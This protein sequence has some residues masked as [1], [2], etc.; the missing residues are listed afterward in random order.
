MKIP[1]FKPSRRFLGEYNMPCLVAEAGNSQLSRGIATQY[2]KSKEPK[3]LI[4]LRSKSP[5]T[6]TPWQK[7]VLKQLFE[8]DGLSA[9]VAEGIK[10]LGDAVY[11]AGLSEK[12]TLFV[13]KH[14]FLPYVRVT[15]VVID[16]IKR[17][18]LIKL[19]DRVNVFAEHGAVIYQKGQGWGFAELDH[20][21]RYEGAFEKFSF[22]AIEAER[23]RQLWQK[24]FDAI[25]PPPND[26][27][28]VEK[29]CSLIVGRWEPDN[30]ETEKLSKKLGAHFFPRSQNYV[31]SESYV[32]S[33]PLDSGR[34]LEMRRQGNWITVKRRTE[35]PGAAGVFQNLQA[36]FWCDG[37]QLVTAS[38]EVYRQTAERPQA[39]YT[40]RAELQL[41]GI[42][43]ATALALDEFHPR[44][45]V[46]RESA[47]DVVDRIFIAAMQKDFRFL[48]VRPAL[49]KTPNVRRLAM[50]PLE[51]FRVCWFADGAS[52]FG[53]M[54]NYSGEF[55]TDYI[56]KSGK[57]PVTAQ[58][59]PAT[60]ELYVFNAD[61]PSVTVY[62]VG[63]KGHLVDEGKQ[64]QTIPLPG[65]PIAATCDAQT[66]LVYCSLASRNEIA[67]I[68]AKA[69]KVI[70]VWPVAPGNTPRGLAIDG[71]FQRLFVNCSNQKLLMLDSQ[72]GKIIESVATGEGA[73]SCV[74]DSQS[75]REIIAWHFSPE[76]GCPFWLD[77]AKKNFDPRGGE[78]LRRPHREVPALPG[79]VAARPAAR[80]LGAGAIQGQ[81][82]QHL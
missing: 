5:E 39:G 60:M 67:V 3:F 31:F 40:L 53:I 49:V 59:Q 11:D 55:R 4:Y 19:D 29:D 33:S 2:P 42:E 36:K 81:A 24:K 72:C 16:D 57:S 66:G 45:I 69:H 1:A 28:P 26:K 17:K 63:N 43:R 48:R 47:L 77:W 27:V 6:I 21:I 64:M 73:G 7:K 70:A 35:I 44:L 20:F 78:F 10:R 38:G 37:K 23:K 9:A 74:F 52:E 14:G 41:P 80:G 71:Q 30:G 46:S 13:Q 62:K 25:F 65:Q 75:R 54:S 61:D 34:I 82:V 79:R 76:T 50:I 15:T 18:I 8:K 58:F 32:E 22:E 51:F 68:D 56:S 12:E